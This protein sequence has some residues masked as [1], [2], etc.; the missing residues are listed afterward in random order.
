[1]NLAR[2][3]EKEG[4]ASV[5]TVRFALS[6][7]RLLP[8]QTKS[9]PATALCG[10]RLG[11]GWFQGRARGMMDEKTEKVSF[12]RSSLF[13]GLFVKIFLSSPCNNKYFLLLAYVFHC[14][15]EFG[16]VLRFQHLCPFCHNEDN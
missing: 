14:L 4:R 16:G 10:K 9:Q 3:T 2:F 15:K 6:R 13:V 11:S 1:M 7:C 12:S 8:T 5:F